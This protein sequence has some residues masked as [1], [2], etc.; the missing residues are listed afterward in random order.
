MKAISLWQP[1]ASLIAAGIKLVE[2]RSWPIE[3]RGPLAIH[4]AK[5]RL[6]RR[7]RDALRTELEEMSILLYPDRRCVAPPEVMLD[8]LPYGA[9]VAV[10]H[11]IAC[12][13]TS[14][15]RDRVTAQER[16]CGDFRPGRFAWMFQRV[17]KL[18]SPVAWRGA[19]GIFELPLSIVDQI[20]IERFEPVQA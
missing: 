10:V 11:V 3:R 6:T 9:V 1:W 14:E 4:A 15:V 2:T 16:M 12:R 7:Q 5:H 8:A 20:N 17:Q 13:D 18:R 19:Q